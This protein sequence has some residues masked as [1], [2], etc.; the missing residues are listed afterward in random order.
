VTRSVAKR[1]PMKRLASLVWIPVFLLLPCILIRFQASADSTV[2]LLQPQASR[3][4]G[5]DEGFEVNVAVTDVSDLY[6][7]QF[8][9][10]YDSTLI[11]GTSIKEGPF[12][13]G[14]GDTYFLSSMNDTYAA[15]QGRVSS[16]CSLKGN[17]SGVSGNGV[18]ATIAFK[19]KA[20]GNCLL[21]FSTTR[22]GDSKGTAISHT[23]MN[24]AV[25]V[26]EPM[27][28]VAV[29][30]VTL[31]KSELPEGRSAEV[32]VSIANQ[33]NKTEDLTINLYA[34]DTI[35]ATTN[36]A[37]LTAGTVRDVILVW[38]TTGT[39][40]NST[41][42]IKAQALP[43]P[44]ETDLDDNVFEDGYL[45]ITQRN[46]DVAV[47]QLTPQ[48]TAVYA[49]QKVNI[50]VSVFNNG[51][52]FETFNVTL[53]Y[54]N[55]TVGVKNAANLQYGEWLNLTFV[56]DTTGVASNRTYVM[57]AA[58]SQVP[59]ETNTANN[60]FIGGNITILSRQALSINVAAIIP[61]NQLGQPTGSFARGS[62]AYLKITV[63][64]NSI[65][66]E[67]LLLTINTYDAARN[68]VGVI[69][70]KGPTSPGE[71]T[72]ILGSPIPSGARVGTAT[73]YV[74][75]LTDWPHQ[76]GVPYSPERSATFQITGT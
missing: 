49:G 69:S 10:Y 72:F 3:I 40:V 44:G 21:M 32:D 4:W 19:T 58:A 60:V 1:L 48:Y 39:E 75:A 5:V 76:G 74:N 53:F 22:L 67:P 6:G 16:A 52:F 20:L 73:V 64:S 27:H 46:H 12:L 23:A 65:N 37:N 26:V 15:T 41:Y 62:M 14:I 17:I 43:V 24:G 28:D 35:A 56:W 33:G 13:K 31:A 70:F 8:T 30:N 9:L 7:W 11:N 47:D 42:K 34:N 50:T 29:R 66:A 2:L 38:N 63:S 61:C 51:A 55:A 18:L 68:S 45:L 36:V 57:K 54:D 71:T 25:E 59:G